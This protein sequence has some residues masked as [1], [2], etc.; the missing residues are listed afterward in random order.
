MSIPTNP[1]QERPKDLT[2][3]PPTFGASISTPGQALEKKIVTPV[4]PDQ[5]DEIGFD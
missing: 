4:Q 3:V 5:A 2:C 1:D